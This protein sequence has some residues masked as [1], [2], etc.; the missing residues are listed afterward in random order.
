MSDHSDSL[1]QV[2]P[3]QLLRPP[4]LAGSVSHCRHSQDSE[5]TWIHL[6]HRNP[7]TPDP[8]APIPIPS[9]ALGA[10]GLAELDPITFAT[11]GAEPDLEA[12]TNSQ[13]DLTSTHKT[14]KRGFVGGFI[15]GLRKLPKALTKSY[16]HHEHSTDRANDAAV[17]AVLAGGE[18]QSHPS[19]LVLPSTPPEHPIPVIVIPSDETDNEQASPT[20]GHNDYINADGDD[21]NSETNLQTDTRDP[22]TTAVRRQEPSLSCSAPAIDSGIPNFVEPQP[23]SDYAKME[24]SRPMATTPNAS[25]GYYLSRVRQFV[26]DVNELPWVASRATVDYVPGQSSG[27]RTPSRRE[28]LLSWYAAPPYQPVDFIQGGIQSE[29]TRYPDSSATLVHQPLLGVTRYQKGSSD[30]PPTTHAPGYPV[31]SYMPPSGSV[32]IHSPSQ[33]GQIYGP[34]LKHRVIGNQYPYPIARPH[35]AR[36]S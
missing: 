19:S 16:H 36:T 26:K 24:S 3:L 13:A 6:S 5:H 12:G 9:P 21:H 23:T 28:T 4:D 14:G 10:R 20:L 11:S 27:Q 29:T 31:G 1:H 33:S 32:G 25:L 22:T 35:P 8:P 2:S 15:S 7:Q 18:S 34:P 17:V 30:Y